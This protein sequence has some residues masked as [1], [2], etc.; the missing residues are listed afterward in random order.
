[1]TRFT[2]REVAG[3][4]SSDPR[5]IGGQGGPH[6]PEGW[7]GTAPVCGR[8]LAASGQPTAPFAFQVPRNLSRMARSAWGKL[9]P[10]P[11]PAVA[12]QRLP[13]DTAPGSAAPPG[14]EPESPGRTGSVG[15][16][17][18]YCKKRIPS[19]RILT[20]LLCDHPE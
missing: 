9:V 5:Q 10:G 8:L 15:F 16:H 6:S 17:L 1:M 4:G 13:L 3:P 7:V 12:P 14:P 11:Q 20:T 2:S 19:P 18:G